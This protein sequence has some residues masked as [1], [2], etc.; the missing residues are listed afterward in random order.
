MSLKVDD[1]NNFIISYEPI[2]FSRDE[3][4]LID[5]A[6]RHPSVIKYLKHLE[7]DILNDFNKIPL[8]M[9]IE[10][11]QEMLLKQAFVKGTINVTQT[12]LAIHKGSPLTGNKT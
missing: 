7:Q 8:S 1:I 12:L 10:S 11:P 2:T 4:H 9:L 3:Y 6:F 5:Q